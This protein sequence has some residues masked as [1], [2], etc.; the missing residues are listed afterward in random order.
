MASLV[1]WGIGR[2]PRHRRISAPCCEDCA[3][4]GISH[5]SRRSSILADSA[6][7][8]WRNAHRRSSADRRHGRQDRTGKDN[9]L[10]SNDSGLM[11]SMGRA[12]CGVRGKVNECWAFVR[13]AAKTFHKKHRKVVETRESEWASDTAEI[14]I[15]DV[16]S[17]CTRPKSCLNASLTVSCAD[18]FRASRAPASPEPARAIECSAWNRSIRCRDT[19]SAV[20]EIS[21]TSVVSSSQAWRSYAPS[22]RVS[23]PGCAEA[24]PR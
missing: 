13:Q 10:K 15:A 24:A 18:P 23:T 21:R 17:P 12:Q 2:I 9:R 19:S 6:I 14:L 3:S 5:C 4:S 7:T 8:A 20:S 22:D 16:T 11:T 1:L